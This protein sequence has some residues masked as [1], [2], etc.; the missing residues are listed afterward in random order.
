MECDASYPKEQLYP[1]PTSDTSICRDLSQLPRGILRSTTP[2][3]SVIEMR[4]KVLLGPLFHQRSHVC[5][6]V[7][8][9][10]GAP[11][12]LL[13]LSGSHFHPQTVSFISLLSAFSAL[14]EKVQKRMEMFQQESNKTGSFSRMQFLVTELHKPKGAAKGYNQK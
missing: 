14:K 9:L 12:F 6:F 1:P 13:F 2:C 5:F 11:S 10:H 4:S 3:G 8:L 7:L